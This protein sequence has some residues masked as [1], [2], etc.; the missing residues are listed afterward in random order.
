MNVSFNV[1]HVLGLAYCFGAVHHF[2]KI[3]KYSLEAMRE[4]QMPAGIQYGQVCLMVVAAVMLMS[5]IWPVTA[6]VSL[7]VLKKKGG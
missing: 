7:F 1:L 6:A 5:V 3:L 2:V 4:R